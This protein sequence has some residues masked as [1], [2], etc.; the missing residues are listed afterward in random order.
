MKGDIIFGFDILL[1]NLIYVDDEYISTSLLNALLSNDE[2]YS[3]IKEM[4]DGDRDTVCVQVGNAV[5]YDLTPAKLSKFLVETNNNDLL[6]SDE[7][8]RS[9]FDYVLENSNFFTMLRSVLD[10]SYTIDIDGRGEQKIHVKDIYDFLAA[11]EET[12]QAFYED[13]DVLYKGMPKRD[14]IYAL[15]SFLLDLDVFERY[16][17]PPYLEDRF[18]DIVDSDLI[19]IEAYDTFLESDDEKVRDVKINPLLRKKIFEG[20][21]DEYD[22]LDKAIY[23]YISLCRTLTY[24]DEFYADNQGGKAADKHRN[25]NYISMITPENNKVVCWDFAYIYSSLLKELGINFKLP[26][27]DYGTEHTAVLFRYDK[28]LLTADAVK[29]IL[30]GDLVRSKIGYQLNGLTAYN[31]NVDTKREFEERVKR[32]YE[33]IKSRRIPEIEFHES[34]NSLRERSDYQSNLSIEDRLEI[35]FDKVS[36]ST[37]SG[38]DSFSYALALKTILFSEEEKKNNINFVIVRENNPEQDRPVGIF[39]INPSSYRNNPERNI[40]ML[41]RPKED[42]ITATRDEVQSMFDDFRLSAISLRTASLPGVDYFSR[43]RFVEGADTDD[44]RTSRSK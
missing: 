17:Y 10:K 7:L 30:K 5:Y 3:L 33:D 40:Y 19:D 16:I 23:I 42:V 39:T 20:I 2:Y 9:R 34:L 25:I 1:D 41:F 38:I 8:V 29:S 21:K 14:F 11:G 36:D 15:S 12:Y 35:L 24:D 6:S 26:D 4:L 31:N 27:M 28:F 44:K 37:L 32:I 22:D 13:L 43:Y 18:Y